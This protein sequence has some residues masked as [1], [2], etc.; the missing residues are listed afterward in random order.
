M[1]GQPKRELVQEGT[2]DGTPQPVVPDLVEPLGQHMR[3]KTAH[4]L[5]RW[6]G[7]GL[8]AL[9][10]SILIA[11]AD[12]TIL[13][14]EQP[15]IGQCDPVNITAQVVQNPLRALQGRFAGD[16]PALGPHRLRYG[17]V[18]PFL[19]H[20]RPKHPAK[21]LREGVNG[22][23]IGPAGWLPRG[24]IGG[25]PAGWGAAVH[26]RMGGEGTGPGVQPT[27]A[28]DQP[29]DIMRLGRELDERLGRGAKQAVV[30]VL[31]MPPDE[32]PQLL[33][34]GAAHVKVRHRQEFP[35]ARCQPGF[36]VEA[37]T[38]GATA[39]AAG[40]VDVVFLATAIALSQLPPHRFS[41]AGEE[42]L[43]GP[44]MARQQVLP[45]PVQ[46]LMPIAPEDVRHL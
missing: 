23:Q 42:S 13:D 19:T 25:D 40:V 21:E 22:H 9:V 43:D 5:Q 24:P 28:P 11:E 45:K 2:M 29:T 34:H 37:L 1:P 27:E 26:V 44:A 33:R 18:R 10:L 3:Q 36:G 38:L 32:L 35:P 17:Q 12:V 16:D 39:V 20:Q 7:H 15:A 6:Q 30:P 31:L 46:V 8:P 4:E 41:P 14:R